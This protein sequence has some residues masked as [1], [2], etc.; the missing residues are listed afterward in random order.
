[1]GITRNSRPAQVIR[2]F[3]RILVMVVSL[4]VA[5]AL[6]AT[7]APARAATSTI[8]PTGGDFSI[9][10][11][12]SDLG[13]APS[14]LQE[15]VSQVNTG[16]ASFSEQLNR[17]MA[18]YSGDFA[19]V[20]VANTDPE[21]NFDPTLSMTSDGTGMVIAV[22]AAE[23]QANAS[24]WEEFIAWG[25]GFAIGYGL[26]AVCLSVLAA[27]GVGAALIP[28]I[29][30]PLGGAVGGFAKGMLEAFFDKDFQ[31]P[32]F[33]SNL[34]IS[35]IGG[36]VGG[37]AWEKWISPFAK[38][39][40][41]VAAGRIG[42]W[43]TNQAPG[44]ASWFGA[45]A[46][47]TVEQ[48]GEIWIGLENTLP[49]SAADYDSN[50]P[51]TGSLPCDIYGADGTPCTAAYSMDR[52]VYPYYGGPLY[53]VQRAS[54]DT[55][56]D[57]GLLTP[58]GDVNASAQDGFC[59]GTTCTVT[60]IYDQSPQWN[61]LTIEGAGGNGPADRGAIANALPIKMG[62]SNGTEAYGL[63]VEPGVGYR[64]DGPGHAGAM[65][66]AQNGEPEGMYMVASGTH[67]NNGCCFDFGNAEVNNDDNHAGH[68]DAVNLSTTCFNGGTCSGSGPWVQADM[69][70]GLFMGSTYTNTA[71]KGNSTPFVTAMLGNDGQTSFSLN[72]GDSTSGGLSTWY[73]GAL[74]A[75]YSPMKQEGAI[76]LGTGG[77]NSQSDIGSWF[78]GV[79]TQGDPSQAADN[80]VQ[81]GIVAAGYSGTTNPVVTSAAG[82]SAAGPAVVHTAGATGAGASGF[83]SVYTVDSANGHLQETYLP[84]MGDAWTTQDLSAAGGTLP[85]TPPVM[86]GTQPVAL[87]HCG[88]TSVYTVDASSGDLQETYLPAIGDAWHT[89]DL[90]AAGGTLPGTPPTN[91]TPT[92]V[93]HSAGAGA[94]SSGCD[95]YTSVY[96]VDRDGDLQETY[97]PNQGFPGD[98]WHT[99]DLS[100]A[101]G[102]LPGTPRV[103]P[104][105]A[106]V[107]ITH[108][109][110]TSVY[111]VDA[112]SDD[113]QET[114][115]PAIGGSWSTQDLSGTGGSLPG[116]PPTTTTPTA[117]VHSAGAGAGPS[118]CDGY[119]SVYTVNRGSRDLQETYLP[120]QGFPGDAWHTQDLSGTGGS[121]AGT[122]PVA[123][124]T[125][126]V[127]LV[128]MGYTSVYTVDQGSDQLQETYLPAIGDSWS[129]QS[130]SANYSVPET[131]QTPIVLLH[132]DASGVLDWASVFTVDEFNS[133][134]RETYLSN[135]GFPGDP[136]VTQDLS[137][138]GGTMPGTPPVYQLQSSPASWSVAHTGYTSTYTVNA[139]DGHLQETYL[140]AM[141]GSWVTQ[142]LTSK[143]LAPDPAAHSTPVALV[144]DGYTSVYTVDAASGDLQE[145]YL[146]ALGDNWATQNLSAATSSPSVSPGTSPTA[147]FHDGYVSVYTVD[148]F[149]GDLRETYLPAAGFPGDSWVTQDLSGTGGTLPGTPAVMAGTSPV[150]ILHDGYVSVYT[151][152]Q[153]GDLQE[154][155]LPYMGDSWSTQ[156]LTAN[157]KTPKTHV[158]P[159]AVFHD[160]Y[161]S[162]YTVDVNGDLQ[163]TY[164]PW[165]GDSW[166]TQD[167]TANYN[168]PQ[169]I[170]VAPAA[171]Y[172][173]GYTSVYFMTGP[174]D[175]LAEIYLPAISGPWKSQD[176]SANYQ[177][178]P[179]VQSP[180]PLVHYDT[181][182]ALTWAS[183]YTTDASSGDVQETYLPDAGF[184]G[185]SW[186]TQDLSAQRG[187]PPAAAPPGS[188]VYSAS[189][190][191][192][193]LGYARMI[194]LQYA[195]SEDGTLLATFEDSN[196]D[197]SITSYHIQQ[198][199]DN[200]VTWSTLSTV[201]AEVDAYAPFL[202]EFPKQLGNAPAGTLM[203]LG[204]TFN[205]GATGIA[206]REWLSF[207]HGAS[208]TYVGVV[209]SG[210]GLGDGVYE[211]FVTLD[212]SGHL[213]MLFSDERQNGTYSQFIGEVISEDGGLTWS[214]NA[215]GSASFG[216]GEMKV[217]A[218]PWQADR[219]GMATVAQLGNGGSY[220]M[221]YEMCGPHNC[222][223]YTKTSADGDNWGSGPSDFGTQAATADGLSLQ[224]S[225]VLTWVPNAGSA[226]GTLYLTAHNEFNSNGPIPEGQ[227]VV[228]AN[229]D[230]GQGAWS[231]IAAPPIPAAG[232]SANCHIN[233]SPDLLPTEEG[234]GLLYTAAAATGP[235]HCQEVTD[236]VPIAP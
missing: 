213:A 138:T 89:Q 19:S 67:V 193:G 59:A 54:D 120:N 202:Y 53:Q 212:S 10:L 221:S 61:D 205:S 198:S 79:M 115:L 216:P 69:E 175:H 204:T 43:L 45:G 3:Y 13:I 9:T 131:D 200:G 185:D 160:G 158:T 145:T 122:P 101:G 80:A 33:W 2:L 28:L 143:Y 125:A 215:D 223:V 15:I 169:A 146:P 144:H 90:S 83:S 124:G 155:Y 87:V 75:G 232:A 6:A 58:G 26:R 42:T 219:P 177:T 163:E 1:M 27:S 181:S 106:P 233:Y 183:V 63:D 7:G 118:G 207:D 180:S 20:G 62:G 16:G 103:L 47:T 18:E 34:I 164:L 95:G 32:S 203:L 97:L 182:G 201:P 217:I 46:G 113:L 108:C 40:G 38:G 85:G 227:T 74:P 229:A 100:A 104:G 119:T 176:L 209:Q 210:G 192:S 174:D 31:S 88:Y 5:V 92:A 187:G 117:V 139:S 211:P 94:G 130:L 171:L 190:D 230:G 22:P 225:P 105:T 150:A 48:F 121:M 148:E 11:S 222:A 179:T 102:T 81:A 134:L 189:S 56:A 166:S 37:F 231:W 109:G 188:V 173:D 191:I 17:S 65:G 77:D 73:N 57:I 162:V 60:K 128:H 123:P 136:W 14:Y 29:C 168:L 96:T 36:A 236:T 112:G 23:V 84:Y 199:T 135:V 70:D 208:W 142:D 12:A 49:I 151:V 172:H 107:A 184:P 110:Y 147:V 91:T 195:G 66:I 41:A 71:N 186:V 24:G 93:V 82:A 39:P 178:P 111:T 35:T 197:G 68:M 194:R 137:A 206:I 133:H 218:S 127:A 152:D 226:L 21:P 78:E 214:A 99:Q 161:T 154:T 132:P 86:P 159:T 149:T 170:N 52:A 165:M 50:V 224:E 153:N 228:L 98:A 196:N 116:A 76:V 126:P 30:T 4:A 25:F 64:D 51:A 220:V 114:Y 157:Y 72:G 44:I 140:P 8:S 156:D 55:T 167:L 234:G 141:G 129:T 235:N